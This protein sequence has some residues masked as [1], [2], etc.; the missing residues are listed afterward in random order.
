[1]KK[2][3]YDSFPTED[4]EALSKN[5]KILIQ[6]VRIKNPNNPANLLDAKLLVF[7]V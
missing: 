1:M 5:D 3:K 7:K 6:D 4:L 2:S